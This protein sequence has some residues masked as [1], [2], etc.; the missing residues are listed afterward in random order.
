MFIFLMGSA[1]IAGT[2]SSVLHPGV[3]LV[4]ISGGLFGLLGAYLVMHLP[5]QRPMPP[6]A[7]IPLK[8]WVLLI[9]VN[10]ILPILVAEILI[11]HLG[12]FLLGIFSRGVFILRRER[13]NFPRG[14]DR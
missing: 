11:A 14:F 1:L 8:S 2:V 13:Q 4:G 3:V 9:V 12:G 10:S 6:S 7:C 5:N